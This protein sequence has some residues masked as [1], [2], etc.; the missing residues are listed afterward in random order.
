LGRVGW[1]RGGGDG[2]R[3]DLP[4]G[5]EMVI[6]VSPVI[7]YGGHWAHMDLKRFVLR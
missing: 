1:V 7:S 5:E 6:A 4:P 3:G 2:G